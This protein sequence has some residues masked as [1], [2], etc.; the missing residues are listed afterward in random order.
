MEGYTGTAPTSPAWQAG[1]IAN[2][3]IPQYTPTS[4]I[5]S[6]GPFHVREFTSLSM[7]TTCGLMLR[8]V[9]RQCGY[10]PRF[11]GAHTQTVSRSCRG[12]G[13]KL[14]GPTWYAEL[15]LIIRQKQLQQRTLKQ[16]HDRY[17]TTSTKWVRRRVGICLQPKTSI[18]GIISN[19][20]RIT[21]NDNHD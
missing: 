3:L 8:V 11:P 4:N 7:F 18:T 21:C 13:R 2:I 5:S 19:V 20:G 6:I 10:R 17:I 15:E 9:L 12:A 16:R 14:I 1:I